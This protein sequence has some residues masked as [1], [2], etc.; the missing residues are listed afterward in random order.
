MA[1]V[2][3]LLKDE[4]LS[5]LK[6]E[7]MYFY[8]MD[9]RFIASQTSFKVVVKR[10]FILINSLKVTSDDFPRSAMPN[11]KYSQIEWEAKLLIIILRFVP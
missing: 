4:L 3:D 2:E 8:I 10:L 5:C 9:I 11:S 7:K 6:Y 1:F